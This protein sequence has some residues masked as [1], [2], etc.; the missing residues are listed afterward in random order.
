[1]YAVATPTAHSPEGPLSAS[2]VPPPAVP[3]SETDAVFMALF[4]VHRDRVFSTALRLTGRRHDAEDLAAE[5]FLRAYRSLSGFDHERL[6]TLQPRA[7][8]TAIVVN[9]WRNQRRT[10]S[11]RPV[12]VSSDAV[13]DADPVDALPGV[14]RRVE[15]HDDGDRLAALLIELP[16]RQRIAVVLRYIGDLPVGEIAEVMGCPTG[17]VKSLISRGLARLRPAGPGAGIRE[18]T[19][20]GGLR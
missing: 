13:A 11:R 7:W 5:A 4:E 9:Q 18:A 10:A 20:G 17:T 2:T 14:E 1:M 16:E 8:L 19:D 6:E 12:T 15:I 3:A